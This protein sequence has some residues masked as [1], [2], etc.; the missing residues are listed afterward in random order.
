M[1]RYYFI[2]L[3]LLFI[4]L[5]LYYFFY[6]KIYESFE[7]NKI[8][9]V[10]SRY[11]EK[12]NWLNN[13]LFNY[14]VIIYNKGVNNN[15][16]KPSQHKIIKLKNIGRT[17][18]TI[19]YHIIKNYDNLADITV[20]LHGS[21]DHERKYNHVKKLMKLVKKTNKSVFFS[22]VYYDSIQTQL[23]DFIMDEYASSDK[24]NYKLNNEKTLVK[25]NIRPFG[26]WYDNMF[27]S[28]V[29]THHCAE[30]DL[31]AVSKK[32]ILQHPIDHYK[33]LIKETKMGSNP[34]TGHYFERS[35][36]AVFYP[37]DDLIT[38]K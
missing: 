38:F 11:N 31:I 25:S 33:R 26:K 15:F 21:S 37:M 30:T 17:S 32:H 12:L 3:C 16:Y 8:E 2:I 4:V 5:L 29:I 9:I 1:D 22:P 23:Y 34:E 7:N 27:G 20:F 13:K 14:P 6:K 10:I 19:L 35:W 28:N 36:E 18:H 24:D